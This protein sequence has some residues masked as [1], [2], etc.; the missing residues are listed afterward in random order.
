MPL[1]SHKWIVRDGPRKRPI[2]PSPQPLAIKMNRKKVLTLAVSG[3]F[4]LGLAASFVPFFFSMSPSEATY[5]SLTTVDLR[6]IENSQYLQIGPED[7]GQSLT[8]WLILRT[9]NGQLYVYSFPLYKSR[10]IMPDIVWGTFGGFCRDFGPEQDGGYLKHNGAIK[11]HDLD[12]AKGL[13][14]EWQW[15]Y[16]G[17]NRGQYTADLQAPDFTIE[18]NTLFL[19]KK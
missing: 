1:R 7:H 6:N 19:V 12:L 17:K 5:N 9:R 16:D 4:V 8:S 11:C 3:M 13:I 2:R 15:S 10:Y 14:E 18:G